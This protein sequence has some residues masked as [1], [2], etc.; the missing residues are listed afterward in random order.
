[1]NVL[2][3]NRYFWP[4]N[5]SEEP[6]MLK[7]V[8]NHHLSKGDYVTAAQALKIRGFTQNTLALIVFQHRVFSRRPTVS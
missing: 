1:M 8:V 5:I 3:V 2:I 4:E 7:E 6:F